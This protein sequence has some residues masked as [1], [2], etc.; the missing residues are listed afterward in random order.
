VSDGHQYED[1]YEYSLAQQGEHIEPGY[2]EC[3]ATFTGQFAVASL[4]EPVR[5]D[6]L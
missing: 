4:A 2:S 5:G 6:A 3:A 1:I